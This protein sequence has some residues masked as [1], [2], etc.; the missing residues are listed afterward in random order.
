MQQGESQAITII[1]RTPISK[2]S[3]LCIV[4]IAGT[5]YLMSVSDT[6]NEVMKELS[7]EEQIEIDRRVEEKRKKAAASLDF[8]KQAESSKQFFKKLKEKYYDRV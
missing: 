6:G 5:Y 8:K 4:E 3:A 7:K 2:S 1:E